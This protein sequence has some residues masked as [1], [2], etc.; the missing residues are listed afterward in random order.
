MGTIESGFIGQSVRRK[1]DARFLLGAGQYTDDVTLPNQTHAYFL[2]FNASKDLFV[3][4]LET[5]IRSG[6]LRALARRHVDFEEG[7]IRFIQQK[8]GRACRIGRI[9]E[10]VDVDVRVADVPEDHVPAGELLLQPSPIDRQHLAILRQG[11]RVIGIHL[12]R[13][14]PPH[15]VFTNM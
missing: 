7:W 6:D 1:E 10:Q 9:A 13:A 5:G 11:H 2:R 12:H 15:R 8:T 4:A 3:V 14:R